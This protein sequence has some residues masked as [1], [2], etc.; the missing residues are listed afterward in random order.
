MFT[1]RQITQEVSFC[2]L[3]L[4]CLFSSRKLYKWYPQQV[5]QTEEFGDFDLNK[6]CVKLLK[7]F[8]IKYFNIVK[9]IYNQAHEYVYVLLLCVLGL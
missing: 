8:L 9:S 6:L 5:A 4:A 1:N 7:F 3:M 2:V